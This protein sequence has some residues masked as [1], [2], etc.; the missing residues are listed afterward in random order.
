MKKSLLTIIVAFCASLGAWSQVALPD[1]HV[2]GKW[3]VDD[4]N[5]RVVLHGVMD[6]P[7]M[8]FNGNRWGG[9]Y[10]DNGATNCLA[11]FEKLFAGLENAYCDVFRLHLD[12]AWT[13]DPN[14][15]R[16]PDV[17]GKANEAN[18]SQFSAD[19]LRYFMEKLYLPL[20]KKA[21]NHGM[22][23]VVRPPGVC[24]ADLKVGDYYQDYLL[25]VWDIVSSN[26]MIQKYA[27][28]ISLELANEPVRLTN[29]YGYDDPSALHDYF[30]PVVDK[31]RENGFTGV[32]WIP[33]TGWQSNYTSYVTHPI[34]GYNIGYAVHDYTGWYGCSD[35]SVDNDNDISIS[36]QKKIDQFHNQVPVVDTNPII[37]TEVDW[38]P[39]KPGAGHYNEHGT[40]VESNYGTW[41]TG[42]TSK[43]GVCY[44]A[45]LD[46]YKNVSMTLSGTGCLIDIDQLLADGSVVPAFDGLEEA[47]GKTCMDWYAESSM[48]VNT[49]LEFTGFGNPITSL[50]QLESGEKFIISDGSSLMCYLGSQNAQYNDLASL[51]PCS[52]YYF[53]LTKIEGLDTDGDGNADDDLYAVNIMDE[54]GFPFPAPYN[55]GSNVNITSWNSLFS[56]SAQEGVANNY[57][58][59][60]EYWGLWRINKTSEGFSFRSA[61]RG[62]YMKIGG[63]QD[64]EASLQLYDGITYEVER[65]GVLSKEDNEADDDIFALSKATGYDSETGLM[66]NGGWVFDEPVN[67]YDWDYILIATSN[68]ASDA[69]HEISITD[70]NGKTVNGEGYLGFVAGTGGKMWLDFW[71]NQNIIRISVD[72]LREVE[73]MDV[74]KITSLTIGGTVSLSCICLTDY[75]NTK[76]NGGYADGDVV[77]EYSTSDHFGTICLPY[78]AICAGAEVYSI[79]GGSSS[80]ISLTKVE[81]LMEAGK[82]YIYLATDVN[83]K[84]NG[85]GV[86]NVNFFRADLEQFDVSTPL[87]D[88]GLIGTFSQMTVPQGDNFFV[89]NG[90][91]LYY[92]T[93][94]SVSLGANRAYVNSAN[95]QNVATG[96]TFVSFDAVNGVRSVSSNPADNGNIFDLQGR[97]VRKPGRGI[98]VSNGKKIVKL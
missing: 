52:Y 40:W 41:S 19:R 55:L 67:I 53:T 88:N 79:A 94:A 15:P 29:S 33:G 54:D 71:N 5:N 28:Q 46:R 23:V 30:Q 83:G 92:T 72:Y 87:E 63:T 31:I 35:E 8:Y 4:N 51:S 65:I 77:R 76:V 12:P 58:T 80:G 11:Y 61:G 50:A 27:G 64:S 96:R 86:V 39:Y 43:W 78:K 68:T 26:E 74:T 62:R 13:N 42:S 21:M 2:D 45:M 49:V 34:T 20:M 17:E 81:G 6:T 69:S 95:I 32:I 82:P 98:Y 24:P 59:D 18:I 9:G 60:N 14:I 38:S 25:T 1:L 16:D 56:G 36:K 48:G 10:N 89:L 44:K 84:N 57:G 22:Y 7:S 75:D 70:A 85:K 3:L 47:C 91:K 93:G 37:I 73:K 66:T 90:N 97:E